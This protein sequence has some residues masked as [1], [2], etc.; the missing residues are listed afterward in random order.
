ME[1]F[2]KLLGSPA[3][4]GGSR[5]ICVTHGGVRAVIYVRRSSGTLVCNEVRE[6]GL[7]TSTESRDPRWPRSIIHTLEYGAH[8][9][10]RLLPTQKEE[11]EPFLSD[12][13]LKG[14]AAE[15]LETIKFSH[16]SLGDVS[17]GFGYGG[18]RSAGPTLA[19]RE[20]EGE[21]NLLSY[22]HQQTGTYT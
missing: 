16:G 4:S 2:E 20:E 13:I 15:T 10:P 9:N 11:W 8:Q 5:V 18:R 3:R 6:G 22:I 21:N 17:S 19:G 14:G 12:P 7:A 1:S